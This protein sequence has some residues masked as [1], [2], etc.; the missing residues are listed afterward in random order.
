MISKRT[1]VG[2]EQV[3]RPAGV[4]R[5]A[6]HGQ[7]RGA[8]PAQ[9]RHLELLRRRPVGPGRAR[10]GGARGGRGGRRRGRVVVLAFAHF[11]EFSR[12]SDSLAKM[13]QFL[14]ASLNLSIFVLEV[15]PRQVRVGSFLMICT[16][17][18]Y[19]YFCRK[20]GKCCT[21]KYYVRKIQN[22]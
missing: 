16:V 1:V 7:R 8:G 9:P 13:K 10:R 17:K 22:P 2:A 12:S 15:V 6:R 4:S 19:W 20:N 3:S 21:I 5:V 11:L 14:P 18:Y